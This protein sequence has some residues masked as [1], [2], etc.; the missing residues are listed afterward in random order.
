MLQRVARAS[1]RFMARIAGVFS[2]LSLVAAVL[3]EFVFRRFEIAGDLIAVSGNIVV[4]LLLY[5]IFKPVNKGLSLLA[6]SFNFVGLTFGVF[7]WTPRG[8]D[9][10]VVFA[11]F[12][13]VA[14]VT[15][16]AAAAEQK[17]LQVCEQL[18]RGEISRVN[19]FAAATLFR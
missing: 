10:T 5:Y 15:S 4:T 7:R 18:V 14:S 2:L 1:P 16:C 11:G 9:I 6:A 12:N 19:C 17:N 3:G 8:V 13:H